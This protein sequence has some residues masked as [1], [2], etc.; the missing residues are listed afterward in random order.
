ALRTGASFKSLAAMIGVDVFSGAGGMSLG[1]RWAGI[2]VRVA[3]EIGLPAART[4]AQNH[5]QCLMI[6]GDMRHIGAV[7][8][9][10]RRNQRLVLFGGPPCQAFSTSNQ[11][12]RG[13]NNEKNVLYREFVKL[14][15]SLQPDWVVFENVP[16][17]LES[18]SKCYVHDIRER[19]HELGF[20]T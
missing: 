9:G 20:R 19:L 15:A 6:Q 8:N 12:T 10:R 3:I 2:E 5:P 11:R 1:D 4:H 13:P 16:G 18:H 7:L 14:I 17:I